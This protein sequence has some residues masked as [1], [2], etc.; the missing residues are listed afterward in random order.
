MI[1]LYEQHRSA[2][3]EE[4]RN[5]RACANAFVRAC[6][7]GDDPESLRA[8]AELLSQETIGGW[9]IAIRKIA[10]EVTKVSPKIQLAFLDVWIQTQVLPLKVGDH[11]A[12]CVAA[13]VLM[14]KYSG[15]PVRLY[16]GTAMHERRRRIYGVSWTS[17]IHIAEKFAQERRYGEDSVVL[18]TVAPAEAIICAIGESSGHLYDENE[19]AVDRWRLGDVRVVKRYKDLAGLA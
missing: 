6:L 8:S 14:P 15:A 16:R 18:E 19:Y 7:S 10:R 11:R 9:T 17:D 2:I 12:L 1:G 13:R 5:A 4:R 3:R